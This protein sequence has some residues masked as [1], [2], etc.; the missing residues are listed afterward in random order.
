MGVFWRLQPRCALKT[1]VTFT[2][3][4]TFVFVEGSDIDV[5][6]MTSDDV[7]KCS[8]CYSYSCCM[9][10]VFSRLVGKLLGRPYN[11]L[12]NATLRGDSFKDRKN[13]R[14]DP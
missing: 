10:A 1:I 13:Q 3:P 6:I 7:D 12:C 8:D 11:S 2:T 4:F 9:V 14:K 5:I